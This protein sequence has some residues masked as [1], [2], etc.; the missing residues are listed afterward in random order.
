[1][2]AKTGAIF[3]Q[4]MREI[5][6]K[7]GK[8]GGKRSLETVTPEERS[9]RAKKASEAA[10][11]K[12]TA[13]RLAR[14]RAGKRAGKKKIGWFNVDVSMQF[15][16]MPPVPPWR[17]PTRPPDMRNQ[18]NQHMESITYNGTANGTDRR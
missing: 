13:A 4:A 11:R 5:G 2:D 17:R 14:E 10:A 8:I 7:G 12:R 3:R 1:M 15:R 6:A 18:R 9:A 16:L